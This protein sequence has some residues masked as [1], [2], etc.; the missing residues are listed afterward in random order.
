[1]PLLGGVAVREPERGP[2]PV[3]MARTTEADRVGAAWC[4]TASGER[5]TQ[6]EAFAPSILTPVS[7]EAT[8]SAC[9]KAEMALLCPPANRPCARRSR[10]IRPPWL[11][12][13][14]NRS[15]KAPCSRS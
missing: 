5:K 9:R 10:F 4:T 15:D 11:R 3:I 8:I 14:P 2:V 7:S 13:S 6:W 1:M 12:C